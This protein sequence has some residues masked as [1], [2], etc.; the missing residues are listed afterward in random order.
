VKSALGLMHTFT[1]CSNSAQVAASPTAFYCSAHPA[2]A[3]WPGLRGGA[4]LTQAVT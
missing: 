3:G 4:A 2:R 1:D